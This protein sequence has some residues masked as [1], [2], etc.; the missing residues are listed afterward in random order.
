MLDHG[1]GELHTILIDNTNIL[2]NNNNNNK[3]WKQQ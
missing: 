3:N 2:G 1:V